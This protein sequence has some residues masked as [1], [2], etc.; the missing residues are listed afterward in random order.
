MLKN[1]IS[2]HKTLSW[3]IVV[4]FI[5]VAYFWYRSAHTNT[6]ATKY[7]LGAVTKGNIIVSVDGSGQVSA[8]NQ[9]DLKSEASGDIIYLN[10]QIGQ[11]VKAGTLLTQLN[12][13]DALKSVRDA[14]SNLDSAMLSLAKLNQPADELT[15]LQAQNSLTGAQESKESAENDLS[16]TYE[17]GFNNVANAFLDLPSIMSGLQNILFTNNKTLTNGNQNNIDYYADAVKQYDSKATIYRDDAYNKYQTA[18]ASYDKNF[19][20]YKDSSRLDSTS[21]IENLLNETYETVKDIAEAVKSANNLIQ[22]YEDKFIEHNLNP[23][24]IADDHLISLNA[25]TSKTNTQLLNLLSK[26]NTVESDKNQ[27]IS[28]GRSIEE[29]TASLKELQSGPDTLDIQSQE[30]S[31]K[32]KKNALLDAQEKLANYYVR[33]PF[34]GTIANV[35]VKKGDSVASGATIV[36][37]I[38]D[39]RIA[40][41]SLN[42][43]DAAKILKDQKVTLT[44][45]AIDGLNISGKVIEMSALGT[46]SQGVVTYTV[47][48]GFDAEDERVKPGMSVAASIITNVRQDI[49][50]VPN[51]AIKTSGNESYVEVPS[52]TISEESAGSSSGITLST[53]PTQQIVETGIT[54]DSY[55]EIVQGLKEGG[56]IILRT[57]SGASVSTQSS[58]NTS[59][60]IFQMTRGVGGR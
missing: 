29:K 13:Q 18:R 55:T 3:I 7:V 38:S 5:V 49:L 35:S 60:N 37:L 4:A 53:A 12:A 32:Q 48:I 23:S 31:I 19:S 9:I 52:E 56:Q 11:K 17:D 1:F 50:L 27:I 22:F 45:D 39:A 46:V 20:D 25:Y 34:D 41:I 57:V 10:A 44:F 21:S 33:A 59:G 42:E 58:Q 16:K 6:A 36:T 54:D 28:Y 2:K 40:E 24:S 26:I 30:L 15:L 47:K 14:Q 51:S 8:S 43:V